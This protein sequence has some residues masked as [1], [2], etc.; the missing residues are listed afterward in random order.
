MRG[1]YTGL[2]SWNLVVLL[3]FAVLGL[4]DQLGAQVDSRS[5]QVAALNPGEEKL[6]LELARERGGYT[7]AVM[8]AG[9]YRRTVRLTR[10]LKLKE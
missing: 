9:D 8:G 6:S 7:I 5:L 10:T 3:G 2:A 4:V 1:L